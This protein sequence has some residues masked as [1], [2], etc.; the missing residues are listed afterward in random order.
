MGLSHKTVNTILK[1]FSKLTEI[2]YKTKN[3]LVSTSVLFLDVRRPGG[4]YSTKVFL[5]GKDQ[6]LRWWKL[7]SLEAKSEAT[8]PRLGPC[9]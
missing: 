4:L 2:N 3:E 5:V 7:C 6:A 1:Q 9:T 8:S